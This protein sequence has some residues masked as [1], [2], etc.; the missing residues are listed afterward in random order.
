MSLP[1]AGRDSSAFLQDSPVEFD[2]GKESV[3][4]AQK[5][6]DKKNG[7]GSGKADK[8]QAAALKDG[9]TEG[10][11]SLL[12]MGMVARLRSL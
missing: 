7:K 11:I 3:A 12:S 2:A 8:A 5:K 6:A 9:G 1:A 4:K 10:A